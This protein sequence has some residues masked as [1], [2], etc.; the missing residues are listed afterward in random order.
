MIKGGVEGVAGLQVDDCQQR[1]AEQGQVLGATGLA[2]GGAV[3]S[4]ARGIPAPVVFVFDRPMSPQG[5]GNPHGPFFSFFL[6]EGKVAGLGFDPAVSEVCPDAR[7]GGNLPQ[8]GKSAFFAI[9]F[10]EA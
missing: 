9:V 8:T 6:A 10:A 2:T 7:Q 5:F 1:A 3:F 4:P